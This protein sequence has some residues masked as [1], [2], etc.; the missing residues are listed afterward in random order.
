MKARKEING[1]TSSR[2]YFKRRCEILERIVHDHAPGLVP[3][4]GAAQQE[5]FFRHYQEH[6]L[7][8]IDQIQGPDCFSDFLQKEIQRNTHV[9]PST[10]RWSTPTMLFSFVCLALGSKTYEYMRTVMPFPSKQTCYS[11]FRKP[12]EQWQLSLTELSRVA[13]VCDLFRRRHGLPPDCVVDVGLGIDAMAMEPLRVHI[14]GHDY[15]H[16]NVF[17]LMLLP[18]SPD[19]KAVTLH[20]LTQQH[21]NAN[22]QVRAVCEQLKSVLQDLS[23]NVRFLAADGDSGYSKMH[24]RMFLEWYPLFVRN[25]VEEI[26]DTLEVHDAIVGDFLHL[27]KNARARLVNGKITM[28]L[29]GNFAFDAAKMNSVLNLGKPLTDKTSIGKMKDAYSLDIFTLDNFFSLLMNGQLNMAFFILPYALWANAVR[30]PSMSVQMRMDILCMLLDIFMFHYEC[31]GNLKFL[32]VSEKKDARLPQYFCSRQHCRRVLNTLVV[33]LQE[34]KRSPTNIALDRIGTHILECQFGI[35]RLLCHAK[36]S[37]NKILRAFSRTTLISD[38]TTILGCPLHV[39]ERVNHGGVKIRE[40]CLGDIYIPRPEVSI[41]EVFESVSI[42]VTHH[43]DAQD[44]YGYQAAIESVPSL[45]CF[46]EYIR[47]FIEACSESGVVMAKHWSTG[48]ISHNTIMARLI[49]FCHQQNFDEIGTTSEDD[50]ETDVPEFVHECECQEIFLD[51]ETPREDP[52]E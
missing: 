2:D 15:I 17:A 32:K 14:Q 43:G 3:P 39:R 42:L 26:L 10:R 7:E 34:L 8:N 46:L 41:R 36:H 48:S 35:V 18:L 1:L 20:L 24:E 44:E 16:S 37:W 30:N 50:D 11:T 19:Y 12:V 40:N 25:G 13:S 6:V 47:K 51:H 9:E 31:L 21:G 27:L 45:A 49:S 23:F 22:E 28:N 38:I 4:R 5:E 29:D 52:G 33:M